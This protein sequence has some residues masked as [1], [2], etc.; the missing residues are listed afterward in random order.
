[1]K[2]ISSFR[3][4]T[5]SEKPKPGSYE[6][7][8]FDARSIEGYTVVIIFYD[9]NPFSRRYIKSMELN[10][11]HTASDYP[12]ISI[13]VYKMGV[14]LFYSFEEF[15]AEDSFY[16]GK[17]PQG[18]AGLNSFK[19]VLK[20]NRI[21]YE[22]TLNQK[23]ENGDHLK[24]QLSFTSGLFE[25]GEKTEALSGNGEAHTW[26]LVM[27]ACD[28][29]GLLEI[30]GFKSFSIHFEGIGYHDHNYGNE[31]MKESFDEW[32]WGRFH[33][34]DSTLIYYLMNQQNRWNKKGWL[35]DNNGTVT[36]FDN[37]VLMS[38]SAFNP[39]GL[40]S[41]R[42]IE[43]RGSQMNA[44]LQK[45]KII[46]N[47]PFYQ[48]FEGRLLLEKDGELDEARGISEYIR[49]SRI[50]NKVFWPLVNMRIKYPGISHWVQKSPR[51][52]RWTW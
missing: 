7:W 22:I 19:G 13:S 27:P 48:R 8:Y 46:D 39:F 4:D 45:D 35:I 17:H 37:E 9:G 40:R 25:F 43:F 34:K 33:L 16:S 20:D 26:N 2:I 29:N 21:T 28:V 3:K 24:G 5:Q 52:F 31:P 42:K 15:N 51:L 23:V 14:P 49:P 47:G 32:Y 30:S 6:W 1:M 10:E 11:G 38:D 18:K 41:A 44:V 50:Y 12:A 36:Q